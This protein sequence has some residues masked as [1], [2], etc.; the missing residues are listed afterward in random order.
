MKPSNRPAIGE[1]INPNPSSIMICDRNPGTMEL[2]HHTIREQSH[3][4]AAHVVQLAQ[5][6]QAGVHPPLNAI[7]CTYFFGLVESAGGDLAGDALL[8]AHFVQVVDG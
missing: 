6:R 8:P 3:L 7:L 1:T 5:N 2:I 4:V